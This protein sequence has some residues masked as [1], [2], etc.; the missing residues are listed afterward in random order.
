MGGRNQR[1]LLR[2]TTM[3]NLRPRNAPISLGAVTQSNVE[4]TE[5]GLDPDQWVQRAAEAMIRNS[6]DQRERTRRAFAPIVAVLPSAADDD[7][8]AVIEPDDV[9]VTLAK[10]DESRT[11]AD[12]QA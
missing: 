4:D 9:A 1:R 11:W 7:E 2:Q 8:D 12:E 5:V 3:P 6:L 10:G